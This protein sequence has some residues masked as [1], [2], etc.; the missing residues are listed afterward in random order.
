[1]DGKAIA[2]AG[3]FL[4][5]KNGVMKVMDNSFLSTKRMKA[6][7]GPEKEAFLKNANKLKWTKVGGF[8]FSAIGTSMSF[9]QFV[10]ADTTEEKWEYGTDT[11]AGVVG[12][13][14]PYGAFLSLHYS[15][16]KNVYIPAL[17][18]YGK[19]AAEGCHRGDYSSIFWRPGRSM[20]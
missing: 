10:D 5:T 9:A 11:A 18:E 4:G 15:L 14:G 17:H 3:K 13:F 12:F 6:I 1:M 8:T 20:R 2:K 7:L 16:C 19:E